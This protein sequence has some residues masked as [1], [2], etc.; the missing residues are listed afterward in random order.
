MIRLR[1]RKSPATKK[2]WRRWLT[3][4]NRWLA[5]RS[6]DNV[7]RW[8]FE[9]RCLLCHA[10]SVVATHRYGALIRRHDNL[11]RHNIFR[12]YFLARKGSVG[13]S[14]FSSIFPRYLRCVD[15]YFQYYGTQSFL[16][17]YF[18]MEPA[19]ESGRPSGFVGGRARHIVGA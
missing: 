11:V 12:S 1:H 9:V 7:S 5:G 18:G 15:G 6:A 14:T 13:T 3:F 19:A 2:Q 4:F 17:I 16:A 8:R 10:S